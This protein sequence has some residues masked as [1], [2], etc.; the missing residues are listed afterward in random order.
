MDTLKQIHYHVSRYIT[1]RGIEWNNEKNF[2]FGLS[3]VVIYS[4]EKQNN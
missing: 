3:E 1:G 4:G 2:L